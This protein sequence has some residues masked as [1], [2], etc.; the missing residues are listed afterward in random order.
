MRTRRR[1]SILAIGSL[2]LAAVLTAV[3]CSPTGA[4]LPSASTGGAAAATS[5][6]AS[7]ASAV[8]AIR[9]RGS[10]RVGLTTTGYMSFIDRDGKMVG[11]LVDLTQRIADKIGVPVDYETYKFAGLLPALTTGKI[12]MISAALTVTDERKKIVDFTE[13]FYTAGTVLL[14][15]SKKYPKGTAK[16]FAFFND[17]KYEVAVV[18]GTTT[19]TSALKNLPNAKLRRYDSYVPAGLEVTAGRVD[20]MMADSLFAAIYVSQ[21]KDLYCLCDLLTHED[22]ALAVQKGDDGLRRLINDVI[23][24]MKSDGTADALY[25]K[26]FVSYDWTRRAEQGK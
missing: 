19:E 25:R 23:A 12:D 6:S 24:Q 7:G 1:R 11:Y 3:A 21:Q 22:W 13:P 10:F 14:V 4:A 2:A 26:W 16:D 9:Q 18:V 17:P 8:A 20:A 5:P 15:N